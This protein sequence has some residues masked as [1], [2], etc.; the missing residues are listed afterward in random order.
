MRARLAATLVAFFV[1]GAPSALGT[2]TWPNDPAWPGEWGPVLTG[3]PQVWQR[4]TGDPAIVVAIVDTGVAPVA[5]LED[6]LVP[7]IDLVGGGVGPGGPNELGYHGTWVATIVAAR[8]N[9]GR[10][11][12]GYCWKC[13]IMPV[14][15]SDGVH[16]ADAK[17]VAAGIRWAVDNGAR[18]VNVSLAG[19][20]SADEQAAV[21]YAVAH[22]VILIASAGNTGDD[23]PHFPGAYESVLAVAG[24]DQ[25]DVLYPWSS[26]GAWVPLAA[27]GCTTVVDPIIGAAYGCGSSFAP[28]AVAGIAG[29]LLSFEPSL[30]AAR[31]VG[32]LE[33]SARP[34]QGI[35]A[36]RVDAAA[37]F[38]ALALPGVTSASSPAPSQAPATT[39]SRE[40]TTSNGVVRGVRRFTVR[41]GPGWLRVALTTRGPGRCQMTLKLGSQIV[42]A[43]TEH[44]VAS[45]ETRVAAGRW[46]VALACVRG[47]AVG[48]GLE[49]DRPVG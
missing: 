44:G 6:A 49:I 25:H 11:A 27:P 39:A 4:G 36:G 20:A 15:V 37:A 34:V 12:A 30:P 1:L 16:P 7:G 23:H 47:R 40:V 32:A 9:N 18:I 26:R 3:A 38:A 22:G 35:R 45:I 48:Y 10:D 5:D 17:V 29:L 46:Q 21:A 8:G 31:V 41:T 19:D 43:V 13:S 28:A 24:T 42:V 2:S 14:R 33:S